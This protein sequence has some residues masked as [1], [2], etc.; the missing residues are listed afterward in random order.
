MFNWQMQLAADRDLPASIHCLK[1]W[2]RLLELLETGPRPARGFSA[3]FLRRSSGNDRT[4]GEAGR[5]LFVP[6]YFAHERKLRQR[7]TFRHVPPDRLLIETDAPD[8]LLPDNL[9]AF[10]LSDAKS[11]KPII[12]RPTS[13]RS[14][15]SSRSG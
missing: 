3:S 1:A 13:W 9:N 2:G 7:E 11:G 8:Q 5:L 14:I 4:A 15:S 10:P 12:I 6:G